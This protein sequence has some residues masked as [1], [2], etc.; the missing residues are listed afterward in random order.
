VVA[1]LIGGFIGWR[2]DVAFGLSLINLVV[3]KEAPATF[4]QAVITALFIGALSGGISG[5]AGLAVYQAQKWKASPVV[6][7]LLGGAAT[8]VLASVLAWL[9]SPSAG[10]GPGGGAILWAE[11]VA[12]PPLTLLAVC[13]LRAA[14]TTA[15]VAAGGC[16]GVFVPFLAVGDLAGRVFAP[17]LGVGNDLAGAAGAAGGIAGGYR[18]PFTAAM[19][20]LG[21]GGPPKATLTCLATVVVAAAASAGAEALLAKLK[22]L[23]SAQRRASVP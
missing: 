22:Q 9:A 12:A 16:G 10:V 1:A 4:L 13:V 19:M 23:V 6:R 11:T 18:L 8:V 15:A 21:V 7:L 20:V 3:P 17:G 5:L 2:I 14:A